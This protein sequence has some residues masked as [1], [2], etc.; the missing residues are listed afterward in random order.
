MSADIISKDYVIKFQ[1]DNNEV[2]AKACISKWVNQGKE[3]TLYAFIDNA[4]DEAEFNKYKEGTN[5]SIKIP[6]FKIKNV[7]FKGNTI[8]NS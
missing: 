7:H 4:T 6:G 1:K 3:V 5:I 8:V 2:E